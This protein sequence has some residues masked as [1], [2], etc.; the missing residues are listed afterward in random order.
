MY[1]Q[2]KELK[3]FYGYNLK[4]LNLKTGKIRVG[5]KLDYKLPK[6]WQPYIGINYDYEVMGKKVETK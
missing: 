1:Q 3:M 4:F 2:E 6:Q 5:A